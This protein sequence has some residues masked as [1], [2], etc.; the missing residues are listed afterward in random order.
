MTNRKHSEREMLPISKGK[1]E[2][3]ETI[4]LIH[5]YKKKKKISFLAAPKFLYVK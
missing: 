5:T 3:I 2:L 1:D 4:P